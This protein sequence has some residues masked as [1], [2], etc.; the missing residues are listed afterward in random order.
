MAYPDMT[1]FLHASNAQEEVVI[2]V[3]VDHG[4]LDAA[5][6]CF[7]YSRIRRSMLHHN[8]RHH[9]RKTIMRARLSLLSNRKHVVVDGN[10]ISYYYIREY[11]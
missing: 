7:G 11:V 10:S 9:A 5:T 6:S 1:A 8:D 4:A 2:L 3:G